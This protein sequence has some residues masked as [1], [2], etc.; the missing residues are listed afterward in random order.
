MEILS[1]FFSSEE[2]PLPAPTS[3]PD[4]AQGCL[5]RDQE[6][7]AAASACFARILPSHI[8]YPNAQFELGCFKLIKKEPYF[9]HFV[10]A[11]DLGHTDA[12]IYVGLYLAEKNKDRNE[13]WPYL[14]KAGK[15][16]AYAALMVAKHNLEIIAKSTGSTKEPE[17]YYQERHRSKGD[18]YLL[19]AIQLESAQAI[20]QLYLFA[21]DATSFSKRFPKK[22]EE[23]PYAFKWL[24]RAADAGSEE[25]LCELGFYYYKNRDSERALFYLQGAADRGEIKALTK[26]EAVYTSGDL[27][28]QNLDKA[29]DYRAQ[30]QHIEAFLKKYQMSYLDSHFAARGMPYAL[31]V[32]AG[33]YWLG[34]QC[35][36]DRGKALEYIDKL[37]RLHNPLLANRFLAYCRWKGEGCERD[38]ELA[39]KRLQPGQE[40]EKKE[41]R[42]V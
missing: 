20:N 25:A 39:K 33:R 29:S 40:E 28:A 27:V 42:D 15:N 16:S 3:S 22:Y 4:F 19:L 12:Q 31:M 41:N 9:D 11:A 6:R 14:D 23:E 34:V 7:Y 36:R 24:E 18:R 35:K 13:G 30:R 32:M 10:K 38:L 26:L 21:R 37:G 2:G 1:R 8:E 5:H 17:Y